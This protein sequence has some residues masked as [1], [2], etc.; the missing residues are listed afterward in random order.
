VATFTGGLGGTSR[1]YPALDG[2][3]PLTI[4]GN[5]I[6]IK[7]DTQPLGASERKMYGI[8]AL[9]VPVPDEL[10]VWGGD[11][12]VLLDFGQL[13]HQQSYQVTLEGAD[14]LQVAMQLPEGAGV[15]FFLDSECQ[16]P[17]PQGDCP[18]T[19]ERPLR[20]PASTFWVRLEQEEGTG[21]R[22]VARSHEG[23]VKVESDHPY[24]P[25][26]NRYW[27]ISIPGA[28]AIEVTFREAETFP[29]DYV[30]LYTEDPRKS[31][32]ATPWRMENYSGGAEQT[33]RNFPGLDDLK[34]VVII[35]DSA[36]VHFQSEPGSGGGGSRPFG[37]T[38][39]AVAIDDPLAAWGG[40]F[41]QFLESQHP[42]SDN[43]TVDD[44]VVFEGATA[45]EIAADNR[46]ATEANY[47][48][49]RADP[50][51]LASSCL[52]SSDHV[53]LCRLHVL[54]DRSGQQ[55]SRPWCPRQVPRG[56]GWVGQEL[57]DD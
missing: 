15:T 4:Y 44:E 2:K 41:C 49:T 14:E 50:H 56:P 51:A 22:L 26:N 16:R 12:S 23:L 17:L 10:R 55:R 40:E 35:G 33:A 32:S 27:P 30:T 25:G 21:I 19:R 29:G 48:E 6:V 57:P 34:P 52:S 31:Q 45:L 36:F 7:V 3:P 9:L 8:K 38:L 5:R 42:Y 1:H 28:K 47:G 13:P 43:F 54:L 53:V 39:V 46:T 18:V 20:V 11:K 24:P 37:F